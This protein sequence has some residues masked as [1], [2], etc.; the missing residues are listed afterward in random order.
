MRPFGSL[1]AF[2]CS[3]AACHVASAFEKWPV[4]LYVTVRGLA[5]IDFERR[6]PRRGGMALE[7]AEQRL[8]RVAVTAS[9][10]R[11]VLDERAGQVAILCGGRAANRDEG[12]REQ[13]RSQKLVVRG[14]LREGKPDG[15]WRRCLRGVRAVWPCERLDETSA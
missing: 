4:C 5:Q 1:R 9:R 6:L 3:Q 14:V 15:A 10:R 2:V 12:L 13:A 7:K 8:H 11:A